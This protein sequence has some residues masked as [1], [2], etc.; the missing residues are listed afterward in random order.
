M[1]QGIFESAGRDRNSEGDALGQAGR[2]AYAVQYSSVRGVVGYPVVKQERFQ[3]TLSE[4]GMTRD[5]RRTLPGWRSNCAFDR[6]GSHL[7]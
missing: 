1:H 7:G 3:G 6:S 5:R 2:S 4:A